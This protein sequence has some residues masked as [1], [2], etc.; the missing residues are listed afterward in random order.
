MAA[1]VNKQNPDNILQYAKIFY[2]FTKE[3]PFE[4]S[5]LIH[6][7]RFSAPDVNEEDENFT[8]IIGEKVLDYVKKEKIRIAT[9]LKQQPG[10]Y[11]S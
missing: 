7:I 8:K 1:K 10:Y 2:E 6:L 11:G 5:F 4:T 3:I 9:Q